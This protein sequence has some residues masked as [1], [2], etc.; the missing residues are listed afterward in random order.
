[1]H[2][3]QK[4]QDWVNEK[5]DLLIMIADPRT[6]TINISYG[7]LNTFCKF[8]MES[9][10]KGVVFNALRESNFKEAIEVFMAGVVKSAGIDEKNG[11][12]LLQVLGGSIYS[13]GVERENKK[14]EIIN[15]NL[16]EDGKRNKFK[17]K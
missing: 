13:L 8:P 3:W 5:K 14:N 1:M 9:M 2:D 17:R 10:E 15:K 7:G 6:D 11:N 16:K 4:I 12:Q